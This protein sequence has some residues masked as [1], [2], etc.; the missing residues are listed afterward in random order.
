[1]RHRRSAVAT[2]LACVQP[3]LQAVHDLRIAFLG[4]GSMGTAVLRG[5]LANGHP[6]DLLS[7]STRSESSATELR[8]SGVTAFSLEANPHANL[9]LIGTAEA[10]VLGIKPHQLVDVLRPLEPNWRAGQHVISM[11]AGVTLQTLRML[12][13]SDVAVLRTMPNT[14]AQV[15]RGVTGLVADGDHETALEGARYIFGSVGEVVECA[16]TQLDW[17]SAISG[18][19]PAYVFY[20]IEKLE[21][22]ACQQG[23]SE[24]QAEVMVRETISGAMALLANGELAPKELRSRVTSPNGTTE[25]AIAHFEKSEIP[26]IMQQALANAVARAQ[27]I[28]EEQRR[29]AE[30]G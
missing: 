18:S 28:A 29:R 17:L 2:Q 7:A 20:L 15:G 27:E 4:A 1:M 26:Q 23:F 3:R 12:L 6:A 13:P 19:G 10:V 30:L 11:A 24:Q 21:Q 22:I 9:W 25:R 8:Q 5:L 16:E 14:P